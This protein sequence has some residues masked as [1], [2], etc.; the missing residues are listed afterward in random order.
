MI[1]DCHFL[2]KA[3]VLARRIHVFEKHK[4]I[5]LLFLGT[6]IYHTKIFIY[7]YQ[8]IFSSMHESID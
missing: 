4:T 6:S 2:L 1:I 8:Q 3:E 7:S 5:R